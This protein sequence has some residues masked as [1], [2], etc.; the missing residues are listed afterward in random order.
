MSAWESELV[1]SLSGGE[2][3]VN[4]SP[5][6]RRQPAQNS[7]EASFTFSLREEHAFE[8]PARLFE[9]LPFAEYRWLESGPSDVPSSVE[10]RPEELSWT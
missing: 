3:Q 6:F 2:Q 10:P 8:L 7:S 5:S 9:Q 4:T 1:G